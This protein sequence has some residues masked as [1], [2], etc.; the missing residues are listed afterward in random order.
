MR[1][2]CLHRSTLARALRTLERKDLVYGMSSIADA[3]TGKQ[4]EAYRKFYALTEAGRLAAETLTNGKH[5]C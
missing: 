1:A 4:C 5:K 3:P 2:T